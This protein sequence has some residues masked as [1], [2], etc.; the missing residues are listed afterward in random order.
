MVSDPSVRV[1]AARRAGG[2]TFIE[3]LAVL[4]IVGILS[5]LI[6]PRLPSSSDARSLREAARQLLVASRYAHEFAL[7]HRAPCR[8]VIDPEK[9]IYHLDYLV[10]DGEHAGEYVPL[11]LDE[12]KAER[13]GKGL[14]FGKIDVEP[15]GYRQD[16]GTT[17]TFDPD[18]QADG[19]VV[20]VTNGRG[21]YWVV[22]TPNTGRAE[23]S[24]Q[25]VDGVP[26]D[27]EDLDG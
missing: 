21:S 16:V 5:V 6:L 8:L 18:G 23:V 10:D 14:A 9:G 11:P 26:S 13:L 2:F 7:T 4:V 3:L 24:E 25:A 22:I 27:R 1:P 20:E 17:I 15:G 19:A 12:V